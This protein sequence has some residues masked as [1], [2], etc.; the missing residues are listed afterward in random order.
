M[1]SSLK[2]RKRNPYHGEQKQLESRV[3]I[4]RT[5]LE[6]YRGGSILLFPEKTRKE[7]DVLLSHGVKPGDVFAVDKSP[8]VIATFTRTLS[9]SERG[10]IH[11]RGALASTACTAWVKNGVQLEAAHFDFCANVEGYHYGSVRQELE[12]IAHCG[13]IDNARIAVTVL[14]GRET[15]DLIEQFDRIALLTAALNN[16]LLGRSTASV[17]NSRTYQNGP[18]PMLWVAFQIKGE[19]PNA[20]SRL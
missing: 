3:P 13:I 20:K 6:T 15:H 16:G 10:R 4:W 8:A 18:S 14:K 5:L 9:A 12:T 19:K 1:A 7:L 11:R 2:G 17:I